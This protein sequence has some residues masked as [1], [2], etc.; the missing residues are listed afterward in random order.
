MRARSLVF[1]SAPAALVVALVLPAPAV[2]A[3]DPGAQS[4]QTGTRVA[5]F[6]RL[7][8]VS[9]DGASPPTTLATIRGV[10]QITAACH[11]GDA[12]PGVE[13]PD[14]VV[15]VLPRGGALNYSRQT[16]VGNLRPFVI[17]LPASSPQTFVLQNSDTFDLR[18][19]R[20]GRAAQVFGV[21]RQDGANGPDASCLFYGTLTYVP[22]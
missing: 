5:S 13:D 22:R 9:D 2:G 21:V 12:T 6:N 10:A 18:L 20:S 11:D 16:G 7:L 1:V 19:E 8:P 15:S 4:A 14:M 17:S 3:A